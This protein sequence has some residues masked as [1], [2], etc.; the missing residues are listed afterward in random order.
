MGI[1]LVKFKTSH[2]EVLL[3]FTSCLPLIAA[4]SAQP[5]RGGSTCTSCRALFGGST[6][7][8]SSCNGCDQCDQCGGVGLLRLLLGR[9]NKTVKQIEAKC[10][11]CKGGKSACKST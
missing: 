11:F 9:N 1:F 2:H 7:S 3:H 4:I 6:P 5:Q 8:R 10:S